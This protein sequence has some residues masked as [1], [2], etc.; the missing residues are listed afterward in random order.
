MSEALNIDTQLDELVKYISE[1]VSEESG[2]I[3]GPEQSSMVK[4]RIQKRMAQLGDL[5]VTEYLS[6]LTKNEKLEK[7]ALIS[8]LTTH[9]T[10]FFREYLHFEFLFNNLAKLDELAKAQCR[11]VRI[12]SAACSKGQEV[13]S[14][15]MLLFQYQKKN[16]SFQ[17]EIH[18]F[19]ID[20][21]SIKH[22]ENGVYRYSE[23]KSIPQQYLEGNWKKG[24]GTITDF[25]KVKDHIKN[26]CKFW[27][28]NLLDVKENI[29]IR[30]DVIF[31]RNL[32]I[33]FKEDKVKELTTEMLPML[34][35]DGFFFSGL[36]ESLT[37]FKLPLH[38]VAPSVY[39]KKKIELVK[40]VD[41]VNPYKILLVDD[42]ESVIKLLKKVFDNDKNF[43][44]VGT[45]KNGIE[46][47]EFLLTN[48][49]DAMTLDIHMPTQDGISYLRKN[50]SSMHP[51]VI[52][53]SDC[54]RDNDDSSKIALSL[55]AKDYV[56]KPQMANLEK[57]SQEIKN[58]IKMILKK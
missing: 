3:L 15:S 39:S 57:Y 55:G 9:H 35:D 34:E 28:G 30:Y 12:L 29:S 17:F 16:P 1:L 58:K 21:E 23:V 7:K 41:T 5:S 46:A 24:T 18:G 53:V 42:S 47:S 44:V 56:E 51:A 43:E 33:Y 8:L 26:K 49:V 37:N 14:L 50:M 25:A 13:Y 11:P 31:C 19:D 6:H 32:F 38:M 36:S 54:D 10:F 52:L 48:K 40:E 2:N 27:V 4:N 22:A 45:A 20:H